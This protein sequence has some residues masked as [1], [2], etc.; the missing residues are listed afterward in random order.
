VY[1]SR[2][3]D[4]CSQLQVQTERNSISNRKGCRDAGCA[5][6]ARAAFNAVRSARAAAS[7]RGRIDRQRNVL[8]ECRLQTLD[9]AM[10]IAAARAADT[11][12]ADHEYRRSAA[13]LAGCTG[14]S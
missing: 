4:F 9:G 8:A 5:H 13:G 11:D 10:L 14:G 3:S 12:G 1:S 2:P 7:R 6:L